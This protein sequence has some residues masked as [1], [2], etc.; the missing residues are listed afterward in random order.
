MPRDAAHRFVVGVDYLN[1]CFRLELSMGDISNPPESNSF[2]YAHRYGSY[3]S[4]ELIVE[5]HI[6]KLSQATNDTPVYLWINERDV[7]AYLNLLKF[8]NLFKRFDNVYLIRCCSEKDMENDE[9]EPNDSF[10]KKVSV[11][12]EELDSMTIEYNRILELGGEFRIGSYGDVHICSEEYLEK[13]VREQITE[14]HVNFNS[15]YSKVHDAFK[16]ATGYIIHYNV[17]EELVWRMMTAR[18][19][20]SH[21]A[22]EWWGVLPTTICYVHKVSV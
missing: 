22:C 19:I 20:Q 4:M 11:Y 3:E 7:N 1:V 8:S 16:E 12:K 9:Y 17:V 18:Q 2:A 6:Q 10:S 15:I 13:F 21:G 14:K 5:K